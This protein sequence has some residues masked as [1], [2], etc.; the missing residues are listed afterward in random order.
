MNLA[1]ASP[2]SKIRAYLTRITF[3]VKNYW[4]DCPKVKPPPLP[5]GIPIAGVW[6]NTGKWPFLTA[7]SINVIS[8]PLNEFQF[9]FEQTFPTLLDNVNSQSFGPVLLKGN[10]IHKWVLPL[11][12]LCQFGLNDY[13]IPIAIDAPQVAWIP[14]F[15]NYR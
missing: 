2:F 3:V 8:I 7:A 6:Y 12:G 5:N 10:K 1:V 4:H 13:E 15:S 9:I 14:P 11:V